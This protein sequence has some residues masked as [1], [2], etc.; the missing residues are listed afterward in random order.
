MEV[1]EDIEECI[2]RTLSH[3]VLDIVN[4]QYI[5]LHIECEEVCKFVLYI[6]RIHVLGLEPVC[7]YIQYHQFRIL[8][9]DLDTNRLSK[10]GLAETWTSEQEKRVE[11]CLSRSCRDT[12]SC[13]ESHLVALSYHKVL[14]AVD[15]VELWVYL[16]S[17]D[18]WE[19][20][21]SRITSS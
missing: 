1:I 3:K 11:C 6:N 15:G 16:H 8:L 10:M 14:K 19:N 12:L 17:L 5:H 9:L 7:R 20:K 18:T 21:W 4:N 2:L 13:C